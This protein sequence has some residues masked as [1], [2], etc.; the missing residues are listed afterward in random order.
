VRFSVLAGAALIFIAAP[1]SAATYTAVVNAPGVV[2]VTDGAPVPATGVAI[3]Q[4]MKAFVPAFAIVPVGTAIAFPNDDPFY[5]SVYS[6]SPG[7]AFDIGLY[8][9]GPGKSVRFDV[10]GIVDI[11][12]HVHGTMHAVVVV[13]DGPYA[14]T[15]GP[16]QRVRIDGITPGRHVVH[17]WTGGPAAATRTVDFR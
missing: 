8:D 2:W 15:T 7:N 1:A 13:V 12:C 9:T 11:H 5:H 3:H 16:N 14:Q 4:T 17:T 6:D 10:A